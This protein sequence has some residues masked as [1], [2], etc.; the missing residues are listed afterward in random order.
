VTETI[1]EAREEE[2][3]LDPEPGSLHG[4]ERTR[5]SSVTPASSISRQAV[6]QSARLAGQAAVRTL[7]LIDKPGSLVHSQPPTFRQ[8][9]DRHLECARHYEAM[10]LRWP[11]Y[12]WGWLHLFIVKPLLNLTEWITESPA[13]CAV[14]AVIGTVIWIWS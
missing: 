2:V 5:A 12:V 13:R 4:Q 3:S 14:A 9:W 7:A 1:R 10:L 11:R 8:A 6:T